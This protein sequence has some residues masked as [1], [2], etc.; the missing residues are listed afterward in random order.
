M[1]EL[2]N[3]YPIIIS[4]ILS[5]SVILTGSAL[6]ACINNNLR[7]A[8][9]NA[10]IIQ[11]ETKRAN[12][13][14]TNAVNAYM[15][16]PES[17]YT[18]KDVMNNGSGAFMLAAYK[19][20]ITNALVET[21]N[22]SYTS[23]TG[24]TPIGG[25]SISK[26]H[27]YITSMIWEHKVKNEML[28]QLALMNKAII[29]SHRLR[30]VSDARNKLQANID[31]ANKV[32]ID[33]DGQVDDNTVR[34]ELHDV[35]INA[36]S[37]VNDYNTNSLLQF[38]NSVNKSI[39]NV[40]NAVQARSVRL[41]QE[42]DA[43]QA[44]LTAAA[45]YKAQQ[46][47]NSNASG[48]SNSSYHNHGGSLTV[49]TNNTNNV[50]NGFTVGGSCSLSAEDHCQSAVDNA[51]Y[52]QL[53][54]MTDYAGSNIYAIHSNYG[55]SRTWNQNTITINGKTYQLGAPVQTD[56]SP[57]DGKQYF[58]TCGADGKIYIRQMN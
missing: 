54:H 14:L 46:A 3:H 49:K 38:D 36:T 45:Q 31:N 13:K 2:H 56:Y 33:T 32:F 44:A 30:Q 17:K 58:Q 24:N 25:L 47:V 51:G 19:N 4:I 26:L 29:E 50:V 55:G 28:A 53:I 41:A 20:T 7:A 42:A 11:Q 57:S 40:N 35:I 9:N 8:R 34:S 52:N 27:D 21:N 43:R 48:Y 39:Q 18:D 22:T 6:T 15:N 1:R 37:H 12:D 10:L 5:M 16:A 23:Y